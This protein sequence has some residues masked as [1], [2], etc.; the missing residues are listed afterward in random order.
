MFHGPPSNTMK[1]RFSPESLTSPPKWVTFPSSVAYTVNEAV[2]FS[3][4]VH[5]NNAS[6]VSGTDKACQGN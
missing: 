5:Q 4:S 2:A 1:A 3:K 6:E